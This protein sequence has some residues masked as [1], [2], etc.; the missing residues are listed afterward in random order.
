MQHLN[1]IVL[2]ILKTVTGLVF[3][4]ND[5]LFPYSLWQLY[6]A[7]FSHITPIVYKASVCVHKSTNAY[8]YTM[9][10]CMA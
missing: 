2:K 1:A 5:I 6:P 10:M 3:D 4:E 8:I 7:N 9:C